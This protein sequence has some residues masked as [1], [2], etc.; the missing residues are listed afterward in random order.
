M[1]RKEKRRREADG[2]G[3]REW[4]ERSKVDETGERDER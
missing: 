2:K 4:R 3:V 1:L